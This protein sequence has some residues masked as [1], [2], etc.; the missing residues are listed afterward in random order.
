M[1]N[2]DT[3]RSTDQ[4]ERCELCIIGAGISGLNA[5]FAASRH[6]SPQDRVLVIDQRPRVGG[7]WNSTYDYVRLHQP[8][9]MYTVGNIKW[10]DHRPREYLASRNDVLNHLQRCFDTLAARMN[11]RLHSGYAYASHQEDDSTGTVNVH[12]VPLDDAQPRLRIAAKR[13]VNTAGFGV[14]PLAPLPL[15]SRQVHSVSP[16]FMKRTGA[17]FIESNAPIYIVGGGK[18]AMDTA[19]SL[20]TQFPHKRINLLIGAGTLFVE[21]EHGFP[22]GIRRYFG[23]S[24]VIDIFS[25]LA[26]RFDGT[27]EFAVTEYFRNRYAVALDPH[28]RHHMFGILSRTENDTIRQG[29]EQIVLDYL[30]D[31]VDRHNTPTMVLRS[32]VERAVEPGAWF[33]NATGYYNETACSY[34]PY[35][36]ASGRV[37]AN[38]PHS[39]INFIPANAAFLLVYAAYQGVL[40]R[41]PLYEVDFV[42]LREKAK[43]A[44]LP[45]I[46]THT[47]YNIFQLIPALPVEARMDFGSDIGRWYPLYRQLYSW[48][49]FVRTQKRHPDHLRDSLD[50]VQQRYGIRLGLL[51]PANTPDLPDLTKTGVRKLANA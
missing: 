40:D 30:V 16:E 37:L 23:G 35:L 39:L 21:R 32:G 14:G 41:L 19:H 33:I 4:F 17:E 9:P 38:N 28:C 26:T 49:R 2:R 22:T 20:M 48:S 6:L 27:N 10:T 13:L 15:S 46:V 51:N 8:H 24:P 3:S 29:A 5:L 12:C 1:T 42:E 43:E 47:L 34:Q 7:M 18:T 45:T 31:V 36:S 11:V 25:D 44:Y 50:R